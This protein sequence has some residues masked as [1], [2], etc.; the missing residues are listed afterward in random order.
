MQV[1]PYVSLDYIYLREAG[2]REKGAQSL[3]LIVRARTSKFLREEI[4]LSLSTW[5]SKPSSALSGEIRLAYVHEERFRGKQTKLRFVD[6]TTHFEVVGWAPNRNLFAPTARL[7]CHLSD[8]SFGL[9]YAGEFGKKWSNQS[10]NLN[11]LWEF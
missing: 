11:F 9:T 4:G 2:Y 5:Q 1:R 10:V 8:F 6:S 7:N 3:D